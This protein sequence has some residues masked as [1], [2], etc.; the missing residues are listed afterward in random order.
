MKTSLT[1]PTPGPHVLAEVQGAERLRGRSQEWL[2]DAMTWLA[3]YSPG[4]YTAVLD[5]MDHCDGEPR[6]GAEL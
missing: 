3:W 1:H 4:V 5:Y 2:S 6:Y